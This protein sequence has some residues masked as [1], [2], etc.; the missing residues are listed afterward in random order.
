MTFDLT[1]Q[2]K[3][4][5]FQ[6]TFTD[7][8]TILTTTTVEAATYTETS[9]VY[10]TTEI[11]VTSTSTVPTPAGFIPIQ[12]SVGRSPPAQN[13]FA[14]RDVGRS[15]PNSGSLFARVNE[16]RDEKNS[17]SGAK[18][19]AKYPKKVE[20]KVQVTSYAPAKTSV[21]TAKTTRTIVAPAI[22]NTV[23]ETSTL[24]ATSTFLPTPASVTVSTETTVTMSETITP[25]TT[26]TTTSTVTNTVNT[27]TETYYAQCQADNFVSNLKWLP[28]DSHHIILSFLP[29]DWHQR[30]DR[31]GNRFRKPC[32]WNQFTIRMLCGLR[33]ASRLRVCCLPGRSE[34]VWL[35][36]A[37]E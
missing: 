10:E 7:T 32:Q 21:K 13:V 4:N 27:P 18:P 19:R 26:T 16:L 31:P 35:H 3:P 17:G 15:S 34:R 6:D 33:A 37:A 1:S 23:T 25:S 9:T 2:P 8:A 5:F 20:C 22:T 29:T 24:E 30:M 12:T 28:R 14:K 11:T 36:F